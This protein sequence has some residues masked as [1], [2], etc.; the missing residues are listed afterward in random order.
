MA[1]E[2][3]RSL[4]MFPGQEPLSPRKLVRARVLIVPEGYTEAELPTFR[5]DA[6]NTAA[7]LV[8]ANADE[9]WLCPSIANTLVIMT[10]NAAAPPG[11]RQDD[12]CAGCTFLPQ[13]PDL[14]R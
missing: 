12:A 14:E 13:T 11:P 5:E 6:K 1:G 10:R 4:S 2:V 8:L 9:C 7:K 3:D